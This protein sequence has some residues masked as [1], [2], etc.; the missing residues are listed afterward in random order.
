MVS[1]Q[2]KSFVLNSIKY[3]MKSFPT[4]REEKKIVSPEVSQY[5]IIIFSPL[6]QKWG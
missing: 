4:G 1:L 3:R 2:N 5:G 6:T